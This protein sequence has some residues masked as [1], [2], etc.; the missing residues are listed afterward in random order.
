M[1]E[2]TATKLFQNFPKEIAP[3]FDNHDGLYV[4]QQDGKDFVIHSAEDW[5]AIEETLFLNAIPNMVNSIQ[6]AAQESLADGVNF[7]DLD[8]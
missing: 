6:N 2:T 1:L 5:Q 3:C 8:W 4:K 7:E